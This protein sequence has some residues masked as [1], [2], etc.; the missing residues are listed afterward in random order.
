M[1]TILKTFVSMFFLLLLLFL[2]ANLISASID[3]RNAQAMLADA[4]SEIEASNCAASVI[5]EWQKVATQHDY[6]LAVS[7][8]SHSDTSEKRYATATLTYTYE[9]PLL[10][11]TDEHV[12]RAQVR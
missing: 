8:I 10:S 6:V 2:G 11:F 12:L 7:S 3:A 9:I 1:D 4:V 5:G